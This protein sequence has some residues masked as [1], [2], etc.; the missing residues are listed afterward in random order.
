MNA[1]NL[2]SE[3]ARLGFHNVNGYKTNEATVSYWWNA[4][5]RQCLYVETRQGR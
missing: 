5:S 3:M 2:G 4:G 1:R